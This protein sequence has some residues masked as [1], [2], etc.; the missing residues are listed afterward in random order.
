[1]TLV[2]NQD[3]YFSRFYNIAGNALLCLREQ[4]PKVYIYFFEPDYWL[5]F[6]NVAQ[7]YVP[8]I[9]V[10]DISKELPIGGERPKDKHPNEYI[11]SLDPIIYVGRP[12]HLISLC[13]VPPAIQRKNPVIFASIPIY[14]H[15]LKVEVWKMPI[16]FRSFTSFC[17]PF[18]PFNHFL[19]ISIGSFKQIFLHAPLYESKSLKAVLASLAFIFGRFSRVYAVGE[20]SSDI[21][22]GFLD[23][24]Q[25]SEIA[26]GRNNLILFDRTIDL[27]S[28]MNV[29][30]SY[31]GILEELDEW[32][33][34]QNK[35]NLNFLNKALNVSNA[36][37]LPITTSNDPLF[38]KLKLLNLNDAMRKVSLTDVKNT[39]TE[40]LVQDHT[41]VINELYKKIKNNYFIDLVSKIQKNQ[42]DAK[43]YGRCVCFSKPIKNKPD[44]NLSLAFRM[45]SSLH[46][47][48]NTD[49]TN[50]LAS[51]LAA[52]Y[53]ITAFS[54]WNQIDEIAIKTPKIA[55]PQKIS[56]ISNSIGSIPA[57]L[58]QFLTD[59]W[60]RQKFPI[61]ESYMSTMNSLPNEKYRW[62]IGIIG[63]ITASELE[64]FKKI[65]QTC[66]PND[67]FVF[68]STEMI[69]PK[70]FMEN[71]FY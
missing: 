3:N 33:H 11:T 59:E 62:F 8:D 6:F 46:Y 43:K 21:S 4:F 34:Y 41:I 63:G 5:F 69:S 71:V 24:C 30:D 61:K 47:A 14:S 7:E 31:I 52:T 16:N 27:Q 20:F 12:S 32:D 40:N 48:R 56:L 64:I 22:K 44:P 19:K 1:M 39:T 42:V 38:E 70:K 28:L 35:I 25:T 13:K 50:S 9:R 36:S 45:L 49:A 68:M 23:I 58:G 17:F 60:S 2:N 18:L 55:P 10:L 54:K 53:G 37:N 65:S 26:H 29:N 67:E 66:R 57:L 15:S 51:L